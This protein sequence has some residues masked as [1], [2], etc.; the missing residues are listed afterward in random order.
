MSAFFMVNAHANIQYTKN[1]FSL[2]CIPSI[3]TDLYH[4]LTNNLNSQVG[5]R[6]ER[7]VVAFS[8]GMDSRVLLDLMARYQTEFGGQCLAVH[9][10]H[11]LSPNADLWAERCASWCK[12]LNIEFV[13]EY[14]DLGNTQGES[15]EACAR[16]MRY[17][18]LAR[19]V[20]RNDV[21]L[22]G[23]HS[24]DQIETFLLALRRGSGPKGLSSMA[25]QMP[26][27]QGMLLRPLLNTS[28]QEI[29]S[30]A[31]EQSL[32]WLEDES[33]QDHRYDRN[34]L[35]HNVI[36]AL[37]QRWPTIHTSVARS[38]SLCAEQEQ[39]LDELL[40]AP[41]E[42][43]LND[44]G[45][46]K[47]V[48]L[49]QHSAA[50]RQR[51]L[52]MWLEKQGALMPTQAQLLQLWHQVALAKSDAN[53]QLIVNQGQVRRYADRLYWL[54]HYQDISLWRGVLNLDTPLILPDGL[55]E[56]EL[57]Q[58]ENGSLALPRDACL[59]VSFEPQGLMAH[60]NQRGHRRKLKKLF[61]E[62]GVPSWLRRR[63]P[64]ILCRD[65]VVAVAGLFVSRG[66]SGQQFELKWNKK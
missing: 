10:H 22:T 13:V 26:F 43:A 64:I 65:E 66:F 51:L 53:P 63:T 32:T 1:R 38:A 28:R 40:Q 41:F 33:N 16:S 44:D 45:S 55:G 54:D 47:I 18:A 42:H 4:Q 52:R 7:W 57:V 39:L 27:G 11:G 17:Q 50:L 6:P 19:Y 48:E 61:Q 5:Q 36:P 8:G 21:L 12:L 23:Q 60:P 49:S 15:I 30:Y 3:M 25:K 34:Y 62:Y 35:R 14:V 46:L 56:L 24:D 29:E 31:N 9:V 20:R 37:T 58:S 59:E 2:T